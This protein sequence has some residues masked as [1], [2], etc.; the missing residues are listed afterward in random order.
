VFSEQHSQHLPL[1]SCQGSNVC[2]TQSN[3]DL[4]SYA[5]WHNF[6]NYTIISQVMPIGITWLEENNGNEVVQAW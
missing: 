6:H 3:V 2:S 5:N 4:R 1:A